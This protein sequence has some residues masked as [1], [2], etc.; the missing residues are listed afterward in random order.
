[1]TLVS[2]L[3]SNELF[4]HR[5]VNCDYVSTLEFASFWHKAKEWCENLPFLL[6]STSRNYKEKRLYLRTRTFHEIWGNFFCMLSVLN[7]FSGNY[8]FL[9]LSKS[10]CRYDRL[11][12]HS[13]ILWT[14]IILFQLFLNFI[15]NKQIEKKSFLHQTTATAFIFTWIFPGLKFNKILVLLFQN[16]GL[17][18]A[19]FVRC[20]QE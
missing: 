12:M 8:L 18:C 14:T 4:V 7:L 2:Q 9:I 10:I 5:N 16:K 3:V 17:N 19:N 11:K 1:M 13:V 20:F 15:K 6:P